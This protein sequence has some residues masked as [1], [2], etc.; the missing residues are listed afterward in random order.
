MFTRT[1]FRSLTPR[2]SMIALIGWQS[3]VLMPAVVAWGQEP[4][5]G[6]QVRIDLGEGRR[7][8]TRPPPRPARW[9]RFA[10]WP[11]GTTIV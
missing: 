9:I 6:P 5:I 10:W 7:R 11:G 1:C 3:A 4:T 8:R 2:R